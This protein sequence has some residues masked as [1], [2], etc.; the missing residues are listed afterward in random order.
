MGNPKPSL[1]RKGPGRPALSLKVKGVGGGRGRGGAQT[2]AA[3]APP[4][5]SLKPEALSV[6]SPRRAAGWWAQLLLQCREMTL[7]G[8]PTGMARS[9]SAGSCSPGLERAP[10]RSVGELR[11]LFEARCAAVAAAAAAGEPRARG[12]KR[13]GGQVPNGLPRAPPAPVI[14]QLTVTAEEPDLPPASPG[15]PE[16]EGDWLPAVGSH[17]QQPRRLSTSSLSS[18]GSSSLLE[19]SEDDLLS[20]SESRSRGNVQLETGEEVVQVRAAGAGPALGTR[21]ALWGLSFE[22]LYDQLLSHASWAEGPIHTVKE[23]HGGRREE[24]GG[25]LALAV[26]TSTPQT[27]PSRALGRLSGMRSTRPAVENG[28]GEGSYLGGR[29]VALG[30]QR[31]LSLAS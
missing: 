15:P 28:R 9:G 29:E 20:D 10:R 25:P 2:G 23:E 3:Q 30:D 8:G 12:A 13:R 4:R 18:T 19:D 24:P 16:P 27:G 6:F 31:S 11:L 26:F 21:A 1:P 17:L 22:L 14:P 5:G 7:P